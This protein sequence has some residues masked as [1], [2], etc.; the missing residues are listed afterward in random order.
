[1]SSSALD[2]VPILKAWFLRRPQTES[3]ILWPLFEAVFE[4]LYIFWETVLIKKMDV[5]Q[6]MVIK[7]VGPAQTAGLFMKSL[8]SQ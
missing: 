7:Q 8:I 5:L 4:D 2:W 3:D 1:M 6:C